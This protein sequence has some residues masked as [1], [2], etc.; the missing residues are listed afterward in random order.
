MFSERRSHNASEGF[1]SDRR[2]VL[3]L[4]LRSPVRDELW[5]NQS[6]GPLNG[7]NAFERQ[8]LHDRSQGNDSTECAEIVSRHV[9]L[10]VEGID[11][12]YLNVFV[13]R[14]QYEQGII[15]FF[16]EHRGQPPPSAA[17]MSPKTRR[18]VA[19]LEDFV[20]E[21]QIS[22]VRFCKNLNLQYTKK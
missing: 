3:W 15:R 9:K 17:L 4:W 16:R 1:A 7:L 18:F 2:G 5:Y 11:R 21:R 10:R 19:Q 13:P 6:Q 8:N 22:M 20:S 12:M 14:L